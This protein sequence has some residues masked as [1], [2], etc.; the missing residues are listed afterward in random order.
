MVRGSCLRGTNL[1]VHVGI[2]SR[3]SAVASRRQ[4]LL[5]VQQDTKWR[6]TANCLQRLIR[7]AGSGFTRWT[8]ASLGR[9]PV[10]NLK[11]TQSAGVLTASIC[12]LRVTLYLS[13]FIASKSS[14]VSGSSSTRWPRATPLDYGISGQFW[15]R[16]T[17][18][19]TFT[20]ITGFFLTCISQVD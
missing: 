9:F 16:P 17:A 7:T 10:S 8:V 4:S 19:P 3:V 5:K 14:T 18:G 13:R 15:L 1:D 6:R 20:P 12:L 11:K 2:G